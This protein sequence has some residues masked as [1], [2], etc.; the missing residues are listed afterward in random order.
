M[1]KRGRLVELQNKEQ[2]QKDIL[3]SW[4]VSAWVYPAETPK[5]GTLLRVT[6]GGR[7]KMRRR[8]G[9]LEKSLGVQGRDILKQEQEGTLPVERDKIELAML[10]HAYTFERALMEIEGMPLGTSAVTL[11]EPTPEGSEETTDPPADSA[12]PEEQDSPPAS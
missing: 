9:E 11:E 5:G 12:A 3:Q 10:I 4:L 8:I 7:L 2:L 1:A 6:P